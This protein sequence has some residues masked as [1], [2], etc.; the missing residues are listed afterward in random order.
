MKISDLSAS[1]ILVPGAA[2][3][4][5]SASPAQPKPGAMPE[6]SDHFQLSN[7]STYLAAARSDSPAHMEKLSSLQAAVSAGEYHVDSSS[8]SASIVQDSLRFS[9]ANWL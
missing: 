7:L 6:S 2:A 9:G 5:V 3:G 4:A 1:N 8:L